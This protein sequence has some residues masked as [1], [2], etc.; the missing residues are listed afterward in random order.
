MNMDTGTCSWYQVVLPVYTKDMCKFNYE[1]LVV[2]IDH[3][4]PVLGSISKPAKPRTKTWDMHM[5]AT[6]LFCEW[7]H[8][9]CDLVPGTSKEL[10]WPTEFSYSFD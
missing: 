9:T 5:I 3:S 8:Y 1:Y 7:M 10:L 4:L 6:K 2:Y